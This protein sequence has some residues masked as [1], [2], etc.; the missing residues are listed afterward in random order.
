MDQMKVIGHLIDRG[1]IT[2]ADF[3]DDILRPESY[4]RRIVYSGVFARL[5]TLRTQGYVRVVGHTT[6]ARGSHAALW[7]VTDDGRRLYECSRKAK[8]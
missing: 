2:I 8:P 3:V 1:P 4:D 6:G 7:A 5:S